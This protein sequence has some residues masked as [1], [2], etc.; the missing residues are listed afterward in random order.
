MVFIGQLWSRGVAQPRGDVQHTLYLMGLK[1]IRAQGWVGRE[2][3]CF[4]EELG[5]WV[6]TIK[7]YC[8]KFS[9]NNK[10]VSLFS[11]RRASSC[12]KFQ[13]A[14]CTS[15][16]CISLFINFYVNVCGVWHTCSDASLKPA[17]R[18][19]IKR[20]STQTEANWKC[21]VMEE[22]WKTPPPQTP[23]FKKTA[24]IWSRLRFPF[25][26]SVSTS[27]GRGSGVRSC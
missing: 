1:E 2:G 16:H 26:I 27:G 7:V 14:F 6:H 13:I 15:E 17:R 18:S 19:V 23:V 24:S 11:W 12:K 21:K 5:R 20:K 4:G 25:H 9:S 10:K 22:I 3:G 8:M